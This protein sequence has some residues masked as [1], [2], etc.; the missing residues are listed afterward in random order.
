MCLAVRVMRADGGRRQRAVVKGMSYGVRALG[1]RMMIRR[2]LATLLDPAR[3]EE[4]PTGG[5]EQ[6]GM[7]SGVVE[8][9]PVEALRIRAEA[10][11]RELLVEREPTYPRD[12]ANILRLEMAEAAQ[13][14][15]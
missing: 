9:E 10:L 6:P 13:V 7:P 11:S 12:E 14:E 4:G 1:A 8:P 5:A 3:G 2:K 15:Q